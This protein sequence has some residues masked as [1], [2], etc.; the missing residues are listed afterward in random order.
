[1]E[2]FNNFT[3]AN[4]DS[5]ILKIFSTGAA[6]NN[7]VL[8]S[9][10]S[11]QSN[12]NEQPLQSAKTS[13]W[14]NRFSMPFSNRPIASGF[15]ENNPAL[16]SPIRP[17]PALQEQQKFQREKMKEKQ[18]FQKDF[19]NLRTPRYVNSKSSNTVC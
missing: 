2:N 17:V 5:E 3:F 18:Q 4:P 15:R 9:K 1:M 10:D 16:P 14:N 13:H 19:F 12:K 6:D 8:V 11:G 7:Q